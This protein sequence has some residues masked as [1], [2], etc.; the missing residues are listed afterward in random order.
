VS[1]TDAS[2]VSDEIRSAGA[3]TAIARCSTCHPW[4]AGLECG[5]AA[6]PA[7][8]YL[9][10]LYLDGRRSFLEVCR[11]YGKRLAYLCK[12]DLGSFDAIYV[13]MRSFRTSGMAGVRAAGASRECSS[14]L[15]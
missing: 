7:G 1:G 8:S 14:R 3:S 12:G 2:A 11:A 10:R 4:R 9:Q 5:V 13:N 6:A 15:R